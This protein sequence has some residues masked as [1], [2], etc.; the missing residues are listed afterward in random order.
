M[1]QRAAF[2][3]NSHAQSHLGFM[4][5][6]GFGVPAVNNTAAFEWNKESAENGNA[7]GQVNL[8][9]LYKEGKG[10]KQSD[11]QAVK[12]YHEAALQENGHAQNNL[13]FMY[14]KGRGV[15]QSYANA[16]FWYDKAV[17][18]GYKQAKGNLKSVQEKLAQE[19]QI[20]SWMETKPSGKK[21]Q[22]C[23]L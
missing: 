1:F 9:Y 18:N 4:Y 14:S 13:A 16:I 20:K 11:K 3:E 6:R 7:T 8:A 5:S 10:V 21:V 23:L 12:W 15:P 22:T 19:C 17:M 2:A